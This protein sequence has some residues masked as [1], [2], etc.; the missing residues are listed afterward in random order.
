MLRALHG[1]MADY[2]PPTDARWRP[3]F[4]R[5]IGERPRLIGHCDVAPWDPVVRDR[6]SSPESRAVL[7]RAV[8]DGYE[9]PAAERRRLVDLVIEF[10]VHSV[11]NEADE[12]RLLPDTPVSELDRELPWAMA[13]RA[14]AAAWM[15]RHRQVLREA[16]L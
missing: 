10:A 2:V 9:L 16:L 1:T 7:A 11:A 4:G 8:V 15:I 3:W 6:L 14:R 13:W 5:A 12:A